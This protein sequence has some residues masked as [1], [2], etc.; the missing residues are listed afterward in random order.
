MAS[1][2]EICNRA[3]QKLGAGRIASLIENSTAARACNTA[4]EPLRDAELREHTWNFA[5][6]R[7]QI[8]ADAVEP[9]F[10]KARSFTLPSNCLRVL[11]P[12]PAMNMNDRDW[13][14]EG[15]KIYTDDSAPLDLRFIKQ[16]TDPNEMDPLFREALAARMAKEMCEALTQSN[17]KW[18]LQEA[19]YKNTIAKAKRTNAIESV[20]Q[21]PPEDSWI[22]VR[23]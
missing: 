18:Q 10:G 12:Y 3:L 23:L 20:P 7:A 16:V 2:V 9:V 1:E 5:K 4:Y 19:D 13:V 8:A 6:D 22:T 15:R 21:D 11:P 17:T 14:I